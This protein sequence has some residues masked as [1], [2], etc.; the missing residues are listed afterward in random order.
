MVNLLVVSINLF[1]FLFIFFLCL[2]AFI[3]VKLENLAF[4]SCQGDFFL[5]IVDSNKSM[6]DAMLGLISKAYRHNLANSY[7]LVSFELDHLFVHHGL[8]E[9]ELTFFLLVVFL[10]VAELVLHNREFP[11]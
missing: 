4:I 3:D 6:V 10:T 11:G 2:V 7:F 8:K 9:L 1:C 5:S